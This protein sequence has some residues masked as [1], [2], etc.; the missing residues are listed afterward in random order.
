V[1]ARSPAKSA[2]IASTYLGRITGSKRQGAPPLLAKTDESGKAS[3]EG[4]YVVERR[5]GVGC[6]RAMSLD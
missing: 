3:N 5:C 1:Q 2:R 6:E 4:Y